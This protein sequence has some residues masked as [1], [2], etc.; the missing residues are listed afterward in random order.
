MQVTHNSVSQVLTGKVD[1]VLS[2][3]P[4]YP[5]QAALSNGAIKQL[6]LDYVECK[7]KQGMPSLNAPEHWQRL[8]QYLQ[9]LVDLE[10]RLESYIYWG[11]EYII[12]N[13]LD[14]LLSPEE[15]VEPSWS[16]QDMTQTCLPSYWFG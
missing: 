7:L 2:A 6:L 9:Q 5:Y 14:L 13:Q 11:I 10:L 1:R 3:Y 8:P 16:V 15:S 12:Q 4:I